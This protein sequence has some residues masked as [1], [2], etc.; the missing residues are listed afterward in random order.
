MISATATS[1]FTPKH[2]YNSRM[3]RLEELV[4]HLAADAFQ[5]ILHAMTRYLETIAHAVTIFPAAVDGC[6]NRIVDS[7]HRLKDNELGLN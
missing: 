7:V 1:F 4:E 2:D 5:Q 3:E 6:V